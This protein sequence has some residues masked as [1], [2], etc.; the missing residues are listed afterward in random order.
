MEK[1]SKW[2]DSNFKREY[3]KLY[4]EQI[5]SGE[6]KPKTNLT[7]TKWMDKDFRREYDRENRRKRRQGLEKDKMSFSFSVDGPQQQFKI[8]EKRPNYTKEQKE[9][10]LKHMKESLKK[11]EDVDH[12]YFELILAYKPEA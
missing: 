6:R 3:N 10:I 2:N 1:I 8:T 9:E 7:L 4:R 5:L 12:P 11:G